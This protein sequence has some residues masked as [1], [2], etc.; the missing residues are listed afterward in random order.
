MSYGTYIKKMADVKVSGINLPNI[1][2]GTYIGS[3]DV[4]YIYAKVEVIVKE[5][6]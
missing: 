4:D 2:D 6:K 1:S 3:C 5:K